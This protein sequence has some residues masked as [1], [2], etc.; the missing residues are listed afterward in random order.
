MPLNQG[1]QFIV[2]TNALNDAIL[3]LKGQL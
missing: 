3:I 2:Q 1:C